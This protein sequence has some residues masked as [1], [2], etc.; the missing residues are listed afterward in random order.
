MKMGTR[1]I[2]TGMYV[3]DQVVTNDMLAT[4]MEADHRWIEQRTGIKQRRFADESETPASM[5]YNAV[6]NALF[7]AR[8]DK[9]EIDFLLVST[10]SPQHYFPGTSAFLHEALELGTTPCM[11]I[12]AQCSGFVYGLQMA[13]SLVVSGAYKKVL[14]VCVE[15]QSRGLDL[16][17]EGRETAALFGDGAAAMIIEPC[18]NPE[19]GILETELFAEG[20]HAKRL[21]VEA[22]A[23]GYPEVITTEMINQGK[24]RPSM[25]GRFVFKQAVDRLPMCIN[26]VLA[27]TNLT[28]DDIDHFIFHQANLRIN[29]YVAN[30]MGI[31][32]DK[33][34]SNIMDY[35]NT[36]S[37]SIPICIDECVKKGRIKP[38]D[39]VLTAAFGAG[40]NWG[41]SI[42][43]W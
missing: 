32:S 33:I 14:F 24:H 11:D 15:L 13:K 36:S 30:K 37:A 9:S 17:E 43:R 2:G 3:P 8:M 41:A 28:L 23:V 20:R 27:K 35:G 26:A 1:I 21:W 19:Q 40:F 16:S 31:P 10:L 39:L 38:K 29:E 34:Y 18:E 12:R 7:D 5:S 42:I 4:K 22:P 25:D 6:R